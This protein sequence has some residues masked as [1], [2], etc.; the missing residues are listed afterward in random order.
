[1]KNLYY[2]D[3]IPEIPVRELKIENFRFQLRTDQNKKNHNVIVNFTTSEPSHIKID[4]EF[5]Y[6]ISEKDKRKRNHQILFFHIEFEKTFFRVKAQ[7]IFGNKAISLQTYKAEI[8]Y[9]FFER[10]KNSNS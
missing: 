3:D 2:L 4:A 5:E 10:L 9:F 6:Q 1:M 7:S 8:S